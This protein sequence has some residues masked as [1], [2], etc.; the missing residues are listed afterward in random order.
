M[1]L[2]GYDAYMAGKLKDYELPD[3]ELYK[4]TKELEALPKAAMRKS[5]KW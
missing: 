2:S 3:E 4:Y 5:G 1:D